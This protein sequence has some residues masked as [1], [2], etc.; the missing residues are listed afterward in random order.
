MSG[1]LVSAVKVGKHF[2][3][4]KALDDVT[5]DVDAGEVVCIIGPSGS[6]KTTFL[7]CINQLERIDSGALWLNGELTGYRRVGDALHPLSES[8]IAR[9]R[10]L[11]GMVFQRFNLFPHMTALENIT[12]GPVRVLKAGKAEAREAA[13][14]LLERVGLAGKAGSYPAQL[15]GGQQQRV[16][17]ARA[18]A[19]NPKLML[20]DEPTSALDAELVGEVLSV[21]R[22]LARSGMTMVVVTHELGFARDVSDRVIFMDHGRV[23]ETGTPSELMRAPKEPRTRDFLRTVLA[24]GR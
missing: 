19:M 17:I 11:T 7:R 3:Q 24:E 14:A 8:E 21:M 18:L 6:G 13:T 12:E 10:R 5:I 22:D 23:V 15:S 16:A 1:A 4:L 2:G 9:Q 20:F